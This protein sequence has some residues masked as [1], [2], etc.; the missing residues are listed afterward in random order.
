MK[1]EGNKERVVIYLAPEEIQL[2]DDLAQRMTEEKKEDLRI[3]PSR[4]GRHVSRSKA[5]RYALLIGLKQEN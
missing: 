2:V 4:R 5:A 1:N 3:P